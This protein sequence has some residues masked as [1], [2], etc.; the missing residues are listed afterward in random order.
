MNLA[1]NI[2]VE[3]VVTVTGIKIAFFIFTCFWCSP[4]H[5][6]SKPSS[7]LALR[8]RLPKQVYKT[9]AHIRCGSC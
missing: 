3:Q 2:A 5:V 9:F 8:Y 6:Q 1:A 7:K 4:T